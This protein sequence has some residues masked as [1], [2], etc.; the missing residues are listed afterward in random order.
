M[1]LNFSLMVLVLESKMSIIANRISKVNHIK[2]LKGI[3]RFSES[4]FKGVQILY[5]KSVKVLYKYISE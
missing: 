4:L 1:K 5:I 2:S 3:Y